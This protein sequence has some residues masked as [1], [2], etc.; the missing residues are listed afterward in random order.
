MKKK[1][2]RMAAMIV[3]SFV[4]GYPVFLILAYVFMKLLFTPLDE[5][6]AQQQNEKRLLLL[7]ARRTRKKDR[8]R[9][10]LPEPE[11]R[12]VFSLRNVIIQNR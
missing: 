12:P 10:A 5:V 1:F 2:Q 8:I 9:K 7:K 11:F 4:I 6:A 3:L